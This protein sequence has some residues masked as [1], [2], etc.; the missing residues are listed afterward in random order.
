MKS[1]A[2]AGV[3]M[4][5]SQRVNHQTLENSGANTCWA[6]HAQSYT[7]RIQN[8]GVFQNQGALRCE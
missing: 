5:F 1:V 8:V 3:S 7:S 4:S 6:L 2:H